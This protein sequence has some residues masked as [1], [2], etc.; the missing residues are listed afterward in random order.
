MSDQVERLYECWML[1]FLTDRHTKRFHLFYFYLTI[2]IAN[3]ASIET[4]KY[5]AYSESKYRFAVK[6]HVNFRIKFYCYQILHS[7]NYFSTYSPPLLR[8]LRSRA[9]IF[10]YSPQRM[11]PPA[12]LATID[13]VIESLKS[14]ESAATDQKL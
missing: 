3:N 4:I 2:R 9:H 8:Q 1:P 6:N 12:I 7:S 14:E 13:K 11:R 10:V 5:E